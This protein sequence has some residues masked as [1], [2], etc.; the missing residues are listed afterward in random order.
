MDVPK[1]LVLQ[2]PITM[3]LSVSVTLILEINANLGNILME[4]NAFI[5]KINALQV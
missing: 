3:V 2:I 4:Y 5:L 1:F